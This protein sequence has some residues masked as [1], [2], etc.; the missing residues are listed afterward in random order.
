MPYENVRA[1]LAAIGQQQVLRF[2]DELN[3]EQ[4]RKLIG[5]LESLDLDHIAELIES[6]VKQKAPLALPKQIEPA[7]A[8]PRTPDA[9]RRQ[10]YADAEKRG[11]ELLRQ[12]K[13][14]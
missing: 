13:I 14:G 2:W 8:Y 7:K 4:R 11:H 9:Q 12:G 5:Q 1:K 10:L 6:H 3:D